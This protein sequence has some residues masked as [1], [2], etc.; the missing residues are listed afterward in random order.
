MNTNEKMPTLGGSVG[1]QICLG[2]WNINPT[3]Y[4]EMLS[5]KITKAIGLGKV[6]CQEG[7]GRKMEGY[8]QD[9]ITEVNTG[10][11]S[12]KAWGVPAEA[13]VHMSADRISKA[14]ALGEQKCR[15]GFALKMAVIAAA[16]AMAAETKPTAEEGLDDILAWDG[17]PCEEDAE[18]R[19]GF[20]VY[21]D[22]E[23][24]C[25]ED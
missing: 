18:E 11:T 10:V 13:Y 3:A 17:V 12:L 8:A 14:V 23:D 6:K 22:L 7:F 21:D 1:Q 15:K 5:T 4:A 2:R 24:D 20:R 25:L 9:A 16:A 19:T